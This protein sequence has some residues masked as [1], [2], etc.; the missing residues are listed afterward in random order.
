M[1]EYQ[2]FII[3]EN[4]SKRKIGCLLMTTYLMIMRYTTAYL[5]IPQVPTGPQLAV[6]AAFPSDKEFEPVN[7][8]A[9]V[10]IFFLTWLLP[11]SGQAISSIM[12]ELRTSS[13]NGSWHSLHSNSK[14]GILNS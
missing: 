9:N 13:S 14:M 8:E 4:M 5:P 1:K 11:H 2:G 10:E 6:D 3:D 12:Y 7:L